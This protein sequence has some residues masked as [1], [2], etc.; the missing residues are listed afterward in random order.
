MILYYI[1]I[2]VVSRGPFQCE[3]TVSTFKGK[4]VEWREKAKEIVTEGGRR[5][6]KKDK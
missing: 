5:R 6:R 2:S 3:K 4:Y 1:I